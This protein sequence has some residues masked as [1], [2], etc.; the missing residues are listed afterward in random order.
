MPA[1]LTP[2]YHEAEERYK[3]AVEYQEKLEA[4]E[5]MLRII[6]KHKGTEK[7]Q[8][9]LKSRLSKLRKGGAKSGPATTTKT[10]HQVDKEGAGQVVI[11]GPPNCGKSQLVDSLTA[12]DV[13]VADYPFTT[14]V[15]QPGMMPF[16]DIQIQLVDTPPLAD[17]TLEPWQ[18]ALI[19]RAD[20]AL[21]LFDVT[22]PSLLEYSDFVLKALGE[23]GIQIGEKASPPLLVL[24]NKI[25]LPGARDE[26]EAWQE[27]YGEQLPARP[28]SA[29]S[30]GDLLA[31]KPQLFKLL[32]VVRLYTKAP[33][34]RE[35][36][37]TPYILKRGTTMIE[38]AAHIHKD[39]A[40]NF[41]FAKVWNDELEGLMVER[42]YPV[43]D[44]DLAEV[45]A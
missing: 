38:A 25:D 15:P 39:F 22:D 9:E 43:R 12:A 29:V 32:D 4:L 33:G 41:K 13:D 35:P 26:F 20:T 10:H 23:R 11:C 44:R 5:E 42:E 28:F 37:G 19:E 40:E 1:N 31:L 45:H 16:E 3:K 24:G 30:E 21:L 36:E 17:E 14:R 18:L 34:H 6:P 8:A 2:Q 7:L 27:L